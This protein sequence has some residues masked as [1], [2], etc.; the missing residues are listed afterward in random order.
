MKSLIVLFAIALLT[1][2][3]THAER[4][5][6][7]E[8]FYTA[9]TTYAKAQADGQKPIWQVKGVEGREITFGGISEITVWGGGNQQQ[10]TLQAAPVQRS[11]FAES[12]GVVRDTVLGVLPYALG[13][14]VIRGVTDMGRSIERAGTAGYGHIQAPG[15]ITTTTSNANQANV[16]TSNANQA[17]TSYTAGNGG[18]AGSGTVS[19]PTSNVSG[20]SGANSGNSGTLAGQT[21][22]Q[23]TATPTIVT[24]PSPVIVPAAVP[25]IVP[26]P[27]PVIVNPVIV[28]AK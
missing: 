26:Q 1:G 2:C 27:A 14:A 7:A 4:Q 25:V 24:Q 12:L 21:L 22:T 28:P 5:S 11:E 20:N 15:A 8:G 16:S 18:V 19:A 17:N 13:G 3:A 6:A 23:A 9:Q 10:A